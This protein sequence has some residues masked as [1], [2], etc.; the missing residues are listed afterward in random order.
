ML[1]A[2]QTGSITGTITDANTLKPIAAATVSIS[3]TDKSTASDSLGRYRIQD[4]TPG[5]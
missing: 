3:N 2:A 1:L 5:T 4:I